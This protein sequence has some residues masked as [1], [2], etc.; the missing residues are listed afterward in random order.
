MEWMDFWGLNL[1]L[2]VL[3]VHAPKKKELIT[4]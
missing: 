4:G 1:N 3:C 2:E